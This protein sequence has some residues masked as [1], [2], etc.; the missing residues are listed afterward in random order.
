MK[1]RLGVLVSGRG[2]N[3]A[4][5]IDACR[6]PYFPAK[7][8]VV[9]SDNADSPGLK[10]AA[11]AGID[12]VHVPHPSRTGFA[13]GIGLPLVK[14]KVDLIVLAGFMRIL[15]QGFVLRW[16]KRII[17]IHPS[18]LPDF[19]GLHP[20]R[21]AIEANRHAS[22]CTVHWV[23]PEV[24]AGP[25]ISQAIVDVHPGDTEDSLSDRILEVE[26][27]LYPLVIDRLSRKLLQKG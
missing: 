16:K 2:S 27:K 4:A 9:I 12:T 1:I 22:G 8:A 19:P 15:H 20:Q 10:F 26:H 3:L 11:D 17:N 13:I 5:L 21:R 23:V 25:I 24:D 7:I 18:L 6:K 14:N